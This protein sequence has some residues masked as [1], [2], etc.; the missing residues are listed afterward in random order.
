MAQV[1]LFINNN[2]TT[3][4]ASVQSSIAGA[5]AQACHKVNKEF[6]REFDPIDKLTTEDA[7]Q[8][9]LKDGLNFMKDKILIPAYAY[10]VTAVAYSYIPVGNGMRCQVICKLD[11]DMYE[12]FILKADIYLT[13][14]AED[15][16]PIYGIA[17]SI[18]DDNLLE[19]LGELNELS[20]ESYDSP[21]IAL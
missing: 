10:P 13:N 11:K 15:S 12:A 16:M 21:W 17:S 3:N 4:P 18:T 8:A 1:K 2:E 5:I 7:K 20:K 6:E 9:A 14:I 19:K